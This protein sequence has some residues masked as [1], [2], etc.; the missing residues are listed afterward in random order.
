MDRD[1]SH[2]A[3]LDKIHGQ[4]MAFDVTKTYTRDDLDNAD[5]IH[6]NCYQQLVTYSVLTMIQIRFAVVALCTHHV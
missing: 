1:A 5:C 3:L 6:S 4:L 2:E